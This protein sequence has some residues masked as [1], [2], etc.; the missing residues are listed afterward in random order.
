[1]KILDI[2]QAGKRGLNVSMGGRYGLV[3]RALVVPTNPRTNKQR[4]V[5]AV[6]AS[7]SENWRALTENQRA[8]WRA[9]ANTVK[10][11][12]RVGQDG[13]LTGSQLFL[14]QNALNLDLGYDITTDPAPKVSFEANPV[15][16]LVATNPSGVGTLK[17]TVG[18]L[19][20]DQDCVV[21][22]SAPQSA[23]RDV[24]NQFVTLGALP[25]ASQGVS[26]IT[27]LY[28]ARFGNPAAGSKVFVQ[29]FQYSAGWK[30][31]PVQFSAIIPASS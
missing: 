8:A 3:S 26:N 9:M 15:T 23:G 1:M 14:K 29:V 4:G 18:A 12:K 24:C 19:T 27:A 30:D 21:R 17:L 6:F 16:A 28:A 20:P 22:A 11:V 7:V 31:L 5:R 13:N 25:A 2:P 10:S